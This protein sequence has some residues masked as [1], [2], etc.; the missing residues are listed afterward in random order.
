[1]VSNLNERIGWAA[2]C[3]KWEFHSAVWCCANASGI[4]VLWNRCG[5]RKCAWCVRLTLGKVMEVGA[6]RWAENI[7][8][9]SAFYELQ[10]RISASFSEW[11]PRVASKGEEFSACDLIFLMTWKSTIKVAST[12]PFYARGL[13][14]SIMKFSPSFVTHSRTRLEFVFAK[15]RANAWR[16]WN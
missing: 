7:R 4:L 11:L 16:A 12:A 2:Q 1:M 15:K 13:L 9:P 3:E 14:H 5:L 10:S 8:K 6:L